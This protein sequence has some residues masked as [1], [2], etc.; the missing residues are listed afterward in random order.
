VFEVELDEAI[1]ERR[2]QRFVD[3]GRARDPCASAAWASSS[4]AMQSSSATRRSCAGS[5]TFGLSSLACD[6]THELHTGNR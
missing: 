4:N 1:D 5:E 2:A 6:S 3:F